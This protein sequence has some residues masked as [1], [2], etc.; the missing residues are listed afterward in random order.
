MNKT[1]FI[2][3]NIVMEL[4]SEKKKAAVCFLLSSLYLAVPVLD[5]SFYSILKSIWRGIKIL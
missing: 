2:G 1:V 3:Y 5:Y 4:P